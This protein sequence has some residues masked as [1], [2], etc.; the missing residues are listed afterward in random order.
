M[1]QVPPPRAPFGDYSNHFPRVTQGTR[2]SFAP[3]S[4]DALFDIAATTTPRYLQRPPIA[5]RAAIAHRAP[6]PTLEGQRA[7]MTEWNQPVK[8]N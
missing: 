3:L 1:P 7:T 8:A 2:G 4:I 5:H 6:C